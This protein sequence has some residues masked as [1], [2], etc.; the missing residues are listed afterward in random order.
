MRTTPER[1]AEGASP[2]RVSWHASSLD[3]LHTEPEETL[4]APPDEIGSVIA[5]RWE[6]LDR[7]GAGGMGV[8]YRATDRRLGR[9]VAIKRLRAADRSARRGVDRFLREARAIAALNHQHIVVIHERGDDERG[10]FIVMELLAGRDLARVLREDG[11]FEVDAAVEIVSAVGRALSYAHRRDVIHR[12]VK[13]SNIMFDEHGVPKLLDFGLALFEHDELVSRSGVGL[14][15]AAYMAP[16]QRRDAKRVDHRCDIYALAKTLYHMVTGELPDPVDLDLVP[17][18]LAGAIKRALKP[19][20]EDRPFSVDEFLDDLTALPQ[21]TLAEIDAGACGNCGVPNTESARFCRS[22]GAGLTQTC[23]RCHDEDRAGVRHC[24][25]CGLAI[26]AWL[27][28]EE[29]RERAGECMRAGC[30]PQALDEIRRGRGAGLDPEQFDVLERRAHRDADRCREL[31]AAITE[32]LDKGD[33]EEAAALVERTLKII[34]EAPELLEMQV[35]LPARIAAERVAGLRHRIDEAQQC[36]DLETA[37]TLIRESLEIDPGQDDLAALEVKLPDRIARR[38]VADLLIA[39]RAAK[40]EGRYADLG[41]AANELLALEPEL[42]EAQELR[43][44][45]NAMAEDH[46]RRIQE[47]HQLRSRKEHA[48]AL[49]VLQACDGLYGA[50]D[51]SLAL[52]ESSEA[53]L[54]RWTRSTETIAR[55]IDSRK[56]ATALSHVAE[57]AREQPRSAEIRGMRDQ[58]RTARTRR[59]VRV[60]SWVGAGAALLVVVAVATGMYDGSQRT[61]EQTRRAIAAGN[62]D[63]AQRLLGD[64]RWWPTAA[65]RTCERSLATGFVDRALLHTGAESLAPALADIGAAAAFGH[66]VGQHE[67]RARIIAGWRDEITGHI[68]GGRFDEAQTRAALGEAYLPGEGFDELAD[69]VRRTIVLT[70][71]E[72][73]VAAGDVGGAIDAYKSAQ[74]FDAHAE[75]SAQA[76]DRIGS[77]QLALGRTAATSGQWEIAIEALEHAVQACP[78]GAQREASRSLLVAYGEQIDQRDDA[79]RLKGESVSARNLARER[80]ESAEDQPGWSLAQREMEAGMAAAADLDYPAAGQAWTRAATGFRTSAD[81][82]VESAITRHLDD[83]ERLLAEERIGGALTATR[84][85]ESLRSDDPRVVARLETL[86]RY[87]EV[88]VNLPGDQCIALRFVPPGTARVGSPLDEAGREHDE[89]QAEIPIENGF[90]MGASEVTQSQ[91]RAVMGESAPSVFRGDDLPVENV[92]WSEA[93]AFCAR[94]NTMMSAATGLSFRLPSE[95]EWEYAC[96]SGS[97]TPFADGAALDDIGWHLA[98]SGGETHAGAALAANELGL[99]DMHGNVAEWCEDAYVLAMQPPEIAF[100][101]G[102]DVRVTRGGDWGSALAGCRA[103]RRAPR[104]AESRSG[105][106]GFRVA[107]DRIV[108]EARE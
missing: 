54:R 82:A 38:R 25:N 65:L 2:S 52:R 35:S 71:A 67:A 69:E 24:S 84:A 47:V 59:N 7:L 29:A 70:I 40:S 5:D 97:R 9:A 33:L 60:A 55:D 36:D 22:C 62:L 51:I 72:D 104:L 30:F 81:I 86:H 31:H 92:T 98:T 21:R 45:A 13:P 8:V 66:D 6:L 79:M 46:A 85:A 78:D 77:E 75:A 14:G 102:G 93:V 80:I 91:W 49:E 12:D 48:R 26:A 56:F 39:G 19:R 105:S 89:T 18:A 94:L 41:L 16:E 3:D 11:P 74:A 99:H 76:L 61:L 20:A 87:L 58:V 32:A 10:P 17:P 37:L 15:T 50:D 28:A 44:A 68:T 4:A 100:S 27:D 57:L 34:P 106:V 73:A 95:V 23:P 43:T 42:P 88:D 53:Y 1:D 108:Q 64:Y 90:Y 103:A 101:R 107:A 63:G 83:A 96:R